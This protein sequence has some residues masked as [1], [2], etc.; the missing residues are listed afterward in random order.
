M[1]LPS[2]GRSVIHFEI[3]KW[4]GAVTAGRVVNKT[5]RGAEARNR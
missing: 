1:E 3:R 2:A 5:H 4:N